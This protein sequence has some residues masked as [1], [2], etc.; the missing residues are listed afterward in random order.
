MK[1]CQ[2][3]ISFWMK[4]DDP[5]C[6]SEDRRCNSYVREWKKQKNARSHLVQFLRELMLISRHWRDEEHSAGF[7]VDYCRGRG[8][9]YAR[10][11]YKYSQYVCNSSTAIYIQLCN[12]VKPPGERAVFHNCTCV[13]FDTDPIIIKS[14]H[15]LSRLAE[16]NLY[17]TS[18][19]G[20]IFESH[21]FIKL[22]FFFLYS[23]S[24]LF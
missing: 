1:I 12:A 22:N 23:N 10:Y 11:P 7:H 14:S 18:N 20:N 6:T 8:R 3:T 5:S 16:I 17:R 24:S 21:T 2:V 4:Y 15:V 13:S 9:M 19:S